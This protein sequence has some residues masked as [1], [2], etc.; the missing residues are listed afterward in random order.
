M[1]SPPIL[2]ARGPIGVGDAAR[3]GSKLLVIQLQVV[4]HGAASVAI[5]SVGLASDSPP[6]ASAPSEMVAS[7]TAESVPESLPTSVSFDE[8]VDTEPPESLLGGGTPG[9]L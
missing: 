6:S 1:S 4:A 8:S 7:E 9:G 3:H 5:A 2:S